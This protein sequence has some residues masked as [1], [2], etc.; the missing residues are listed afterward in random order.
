[1]KKRSVF[2]TPRFW[3]FIGFALCFLI[4]FG[5]YRG[6][7]PLGYA[8]VTFAEVILLFNILIIVHELGHFLA[9]KWQG[10]KIE[11]FAI[12]MGKPLWSKKVDGVEY[13][14]GT[15]P[16]GGYVALPQMAPMEALEGKNETPRED[17]PPATPGQKI[18]VALAGPV[19]SF[20][21]AVVFACIV[22]VVGRPVGE[23]EAT[24]TIGYVK[25]D[26]PAAKA[27]LQAG[28]KILS[29]DHHPISRFGGVGNSVMWR[30]MTSTDPVIPVT[31]QRGGQTL[32]VDVT[33][34]VEPHAFYQRSSPRRIGISPAM[35]TLIVKKVV[36]DG[37]AAMAGI[38]PKDQIVALNGQHLYGDGA[39]FD[40]IKAN[41]TAPIHLTVFR[42]GVTREVT[43]VP[44]KPI[45]PAE[46]PKD[47]PQTDI[48]I[49]SWEPGVKLVHPNPIEQVGESAQA[50]IGTLEALFTPHTT[51]GAS[52]LSGPIGIMNVLFMV[53]SSE[54]GWRLALWFAV[55]INVN[56]AMLNMFP[57]PILDG[58]HIT[59]SIIEWI[60]KRPLSM[61]IL[62]PLQT[63][64]AL[65]LMGYM[66]Y[67]TFFDAQ[68]SIKMAS[69]SG[70]DQEIKFAPK[71]QP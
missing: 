70:G 41:P 61:A 54:N 3:G 57:F 19:F 35:E 65:F 38:V 48:G 31:V 1:M 30:I 26:W 28:D 17:L 20:G 11:K 59:L 21:L 32:T 67:I 42:N 6:F 4:P 45:S 22:W 46:L 60:R 29:I 14:L 16:A 2:A 71:Q 34:L 12:W 27:G 63:A 9:A 23:T 18:I 33:P 15:I 7:V 25:A 66:L 58:G 69:N 13:I 24:T 68:D 40:E 50:V 44:E 39:I 10:L 43:L 51:V 5:Y 62:E 56:L 55:V 8:I 52:Q 49:D 37:P 53:L 47:G 64:C 36:P